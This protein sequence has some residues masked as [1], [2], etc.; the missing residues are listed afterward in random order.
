MNRAGKIIFL[1]V[2]LCSV[3]GGCIRVK[4]PE[5]PPLVVKLAVDDRNYFNIDAAVSLGLM[6]RLPD[7]LPFRH[8]IHSIYYI[9][10]DGEGNVVAEQHNRAIDNDLP[11][12]SVVMPVSLPY[13][14]YTVTVWGNMDSETPLNEDASQAEMETEGAAF[15]DIYLASGTFDYS[16]GN[17][18]FVLGMKRTRGCLLIKAEGIPDNID[19]STKDIEGVY[20]IVDSDLEY[21]NVTGINTA[22][23]WKVQNEIRTT[24]L[25]CP[26]PSYEGTTLSVA[27]IDK[28]AAGGMAQTSADSV[29][30]PQ[31]V[32]ITV[33]RNEITIL[34]YI[35]DEEGSGGS[36]GIYIWVNNNWEVLHNMEIE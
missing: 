27:F 25:M 33:G 4:L 22:L 16:Y 35:Y 19:F 5:C 23:D 20:G 32:R 14:K 2:M 24:T 34:K 3:P 6:E 9:V 11:E 21:S 7:S 18:T 36:F 12:Q 8:Y 29:L 30:R 31:D 13:G 26:S 10:V 1:A 28:S 15:N 17:D